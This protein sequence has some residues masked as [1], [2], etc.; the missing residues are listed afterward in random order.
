[1]TDVTPEG[2]A[3]PVP[4]KPDAP[5]PPV[6]E[7]VRSIRAR[8]SRLPELLAVFAVR[9]RG[10]RAARRV[11]K[12]RAS[13][14]DADLRELVAL[15][16]DRA[17]RV[18]RNEGAFVG[19]PFLWLVPFAFCTALLEQGQLFLELAALSGK[20]PAAPER[21]AELLVLQGAHPDV[22]AAER[23]LAEHP[24]AATGDGQRR[25][26]WSLIWRMARLLGL[27]SE[28]VDPPPSRWRTAGGWLVVVLVLMVGMVVPLVWLPYMA[29]SYYRATGRMA[30]RAVSFYFGG[31]QAGWPERRS[32]RTDPGIV[33][34]A[35]Q[36]AFSLLIPVGTVVFLVLADIR[37]A[38]SRWPV[39]ALALIG[40][41]GLVGAVWY[42]RHRRR[43]RE[44]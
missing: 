1:M 38:S 2:S 31:D 28:S 7:L 32:A 18:S 5:E 40:L 26:F 22:A 36:T 6:A 9:H 33:A 34:A 39:L 13:H 30:T 37:L 19:G 15:S 35:V 12:L 43:P 11:A 24:S 44:D 8:P 42:R 10:P 16:V 4:E 27:T 20:D 25:G 23:S 29:V 3:V 14:P 17:R 21:T 41:S